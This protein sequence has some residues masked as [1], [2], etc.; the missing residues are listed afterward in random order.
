[1]LIAQ[2]L[3][4]EL[5]RKTLT[6]FWKKEADST[7]VTLKRNIE[8][9]K[10]LAYGVTGTRLMFGQKESRFAPGKPQHNK[11]P[12]LSWEA[13]LLST[14]SRKGHSWHFS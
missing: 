8:Y 10:E 5:L 12:P 9:S 7:F 6:L 2:G 11:K 13:F 4:I 3:F 14:L 1:L